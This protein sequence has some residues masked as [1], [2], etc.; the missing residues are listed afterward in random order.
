MNHWQVLGIA[1]VAWI[2]WIPACSF[3]ALAQGRSGSV[4]ILPGLPVFPLAAWGLGY[5]SQALGWPL[6]TTLIG[7]AHLILLVWMCLS[8]ARHRRIVR[9]KNRGAAPLDSN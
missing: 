8:I 9:A 1:T 7:L 3:E 2:V 6:G 4:S 5:A